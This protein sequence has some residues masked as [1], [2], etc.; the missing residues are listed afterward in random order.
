[1]ITATTEQDG[2]LI[3]I[4]GYEAGWNSVIRI[5]IK[6]ALADAG[7]KHIRVVSELDVWTPTPS[8]QINVRSLMK[9]RAKTKEMVDNIVVHFNGLIER[10]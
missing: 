7:I 10:T 3:I 4:E 1:M 6:N 8:Y 2:R 5:K 9:D